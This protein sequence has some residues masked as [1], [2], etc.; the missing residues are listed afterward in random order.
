MTCGKKKHP[1][2]AW[3]TVHFMGYGAFKVHRQLDIVTSTDPARRK[4]SGTFFCPTA[5]SPWRAL[6]YLSGGKHDPS[7]RNTEQDEPGV[8][9]P[10]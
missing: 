4:V 5:A 7:P 10:A 8:P 2:K 3:Y 6:F 9:A 1:K